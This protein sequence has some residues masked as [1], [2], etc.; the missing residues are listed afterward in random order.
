MIL[1]RAPGIVHLLFIELLAK[2]D[3]LRYIASMQGPSCLIEYDYVK[4]D[5]F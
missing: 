2:I 4:Y 1:Q 5:Y 3:N